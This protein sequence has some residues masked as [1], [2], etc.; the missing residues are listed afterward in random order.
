VLLPFVHPDAS[1]KGS[2]SFRRYKEEVKLK[3]L[4]HLVN[5]FIESTDYDTDYFV[6]KLREIVVER[7]K[8]VHHFG[9]SKGLNILS[10]EEGCRTCIN[11]LESQYQEAIF[12][13][14]EIT[15]FVFGVIAFLRENYAESN[16]NVELLYKRLKA[17]II[18]EVEYINLFDPSE[19]THSL[20]VK[21]E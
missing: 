12:F 18:P 21:A 9:E 19:T 16:P 5:K 3:T 14:K 1:A 2:D 15:L 20:Q 6:E 13:Y 11:G 8:L 7:N 17:D 10:T 4:G